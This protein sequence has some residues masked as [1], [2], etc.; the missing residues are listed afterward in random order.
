MFLVCFSATKNSSSSAALY[1]S[2]PFCTKYIG[3]FFATSGTFFVPSILTY[4]AKHYR[5]TLM[6]NILPPSSATVSLQTLYITGPKKKLS[7][8]WPLN[9]LS[10]TSEILIEE[11]WS[12]ANCKAVRTSLRSAEERVPS[13]K[14]ETKCWVGILGN[15]SIKV[16]KLLTRYSLLSEF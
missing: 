16:V 9:S 11:I 5:I 7:A 6:M 3:C 15:L 10:S 8:A 2:F 13:L 12:G 14:T 4:W 1:F